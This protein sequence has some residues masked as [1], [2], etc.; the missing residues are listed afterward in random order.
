VLARFR[1]GDLKCTTVSDVEQGA[2]NVLLIE[3]P[4]RRILIDTGAG[5]AYPG[6]PGLVVERLRATGIE[7]GSIDTVIL[8]HADFDHIGGAIE[9]GRP[10]F[11]K[12][13]HFILRAEV[14][15]WRARPERLRPSPS[16][17]EAFRKLVN[18]F[19]PTA[20]DALSDVLQPVE[21]DTEVAP[22]ITLIAA[23][24]HT[25]GN[26]VVRIVSGEEELLVAADLFYDAVNIKDPEWVAIYDHDATAVVKTRRAILSRASANRTLLM[27]YHLPFPGLGRVTDDDPG[28]SWEPHALSLS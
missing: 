8:S 11:P 17:D 2:R 28:W 25:P 20:I 13:E 6:N 14:E 10:T 5:S 3:A 24:G 9:A 26:A 22:G 7:P 16:H 15:F 19:P 23:P 18:F 4:G 12:A 27:L 1:I 21:P